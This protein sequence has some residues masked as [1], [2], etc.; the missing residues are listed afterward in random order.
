[1]PL[2]LGVGS[3]PTA[4]QRGYFCLNGF[5]GLA[6]I[7]EVCTHIS[8]SLGV[9]GRFERLLQFFDLVLEGLDLL[10]HQLPQHGRSHHERDLFAT[11]IAQHLNGC[12]R[13]LDRATNADFITCCRDLNGPR[14]KRRVI[15]QCDALACME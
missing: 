6:N 15:I 9:V 10:V 14:H 1:M 4:F 11:R 7:E 5:E 8:G 3:R 2:E 12:L 13:P